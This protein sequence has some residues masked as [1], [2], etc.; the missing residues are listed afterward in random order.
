MTKQPLPYSMNTF[1][2]SNCQNEIFRD[3]G[4]KTIENKPEN[5]KK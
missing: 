3:V 5:P 4:T 1:W 2:K